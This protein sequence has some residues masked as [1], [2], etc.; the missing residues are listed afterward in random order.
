MRFPIFILHLQKVAAAAHLHGVASCKSLWR[1]ALR[2][3]FALCEFFVQPIVQPSQMHTLVG[4]RGACRQS[5]DRAVF[6]N[7]SAHRRPSLTH[8]P[9]GDDRISDGERGMLCFFFQN[10][11]MMAARKPT[12]KS[13]ALQQKKVSDTN[14]AGDFFL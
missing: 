11:G 7:S 10:T 8:D 6:A 14:R 2:Q 4:D 1:E 3:C 9:D 13:L 5:K 12:R